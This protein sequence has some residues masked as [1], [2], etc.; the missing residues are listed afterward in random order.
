MNSLASRW[1]R[2][3]PFTEHLTPRGP[4]PFPTVLIFHG[5]G[6]VRDHLRWYARAAVEAGWGALIVDSFAAR[7]WTRNFAKHLVCTG[8]LLRGRA[9]AADVLA[10]VRFSGE[11]PSVDPR[12]LVLAG[13]SHG[14]WSIMD[15]MA[16]PLSRR[17]EL[18]LRDAPKASLEGV[19]GGFFAYP[20]V[21][22]ASASR[23][24]RP[25]PR[26]LRV[27]SVVPRRDHLASVRRHMRALASVVSGGGEVEVWSVDATHAF[28]EPGLKGRVLA[29]DEDLGVE[30]LQRFQGFL[31][32]VDRA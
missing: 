7:G 19:R 28:D 11:I 3:A 24:G 29:Y 8:L 26:A 18:G 9:R 20:Y 25:W 32:S 17:G 21:G 12:S 31:R 10:A 13:W 4:G 14:A 1:R 16:Q 22:V 15:L 2:L 6:G 23:G 27:F 5:C 30:A